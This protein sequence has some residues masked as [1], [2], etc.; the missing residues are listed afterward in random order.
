MEVATE[1]KTTTNPEVPQG[2]PVTKQ[3]AERVKRGKGRPAK[4]FISELP[5]PSKFEMNEP[6]QMFAYLKLI[7][8]EKLKRVMLVFYRYHPVCD[9]TEGGS[10]DKYLEKIPGENHPFT[11]DDWENQI[12]HRYGS[13]KYGAYLNEMN[14]TICRCLRI[15]TRWDL[16]NYP[17]IVDPQWLDQDHP[18][19]RAYVQY[20]RGR[21]IKLPTQKEKEEEQG[22]MQLAETNSKLID[23]LI[24]R[25]TPVPQVRQDTVNERIALETAKAGIE[26]ATSQAKQI[27]TS[28]VKGS[29]PLELVNSIVS[30]AEK[31]NPKNGADSTTTLILK[32]AM[33]QAEEARKEAAETRRE[34]F[35]LLRES[36]KPAQ[37]KSFLDQVREIAEMK[38]LMKE[39][40]GVGDGGGETEGAAVAGKES[41]PELL[42]K[43]APQL[44]Q[45]GLGMWQQFNHS[46]AHASRMKEMETLAKTGQLPPGAAPIV[47]PQVQQ[48][49][50][51]QQQQTAQNQPQQQQGA[52]VEPVP[53]ASPEALA[54]YEKYK[55]YHWIVGALQESIISHLND[56]SKDGCDFANWLVDGYGR[57]QYITIKNMGEEA[58]MGA[59]KTYSSLWQRIS[60]M[61]PEVRKFIHEF[62]TRDEIVA[63]EANEQGDDDNEDENEGE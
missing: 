12:L 46:M 38:A 27:M 32:N 57:T 45:T 17:P 19:N 10:K 1:V 33:D 35:Q 22:D 15:E 25:T 60:G 49:Q 43:S 63:A 9:E 26:M 18:Q 56:E 36:N 53:T 39:A 20:L 59:I 28:N 4:P 50:P 54:E 23:T 16:E 6:G 2:V 21:G 41:I 48:A 62:V 11:D 55:Q 58:L 44:L 42:I 31:M 7:P 51:A 13:G 3:E 52:P 5:P 29:D 30:V 24:A 61:E 40:F 34:M 47:M 14:R 37:P 8:E